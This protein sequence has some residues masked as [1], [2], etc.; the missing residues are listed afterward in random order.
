MNLRRWRAK[1]DEIRPES[2]HNLSRER[3]WW[4]VY[5]WCQLQSEWSSSRKVGGRVVWADV[6]ADSEPFNV[7]SR[8]LQHVIEFSEKSDSLGTNRGQV[9]SNKGSL[10]KIHPEWALF[11]GNVCK[12]LDILL[13][14]SID[15]FFTKLYIKFFLRNSKILFQNSIIFHKVLQIRSYFNKILLKLENLIEII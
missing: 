4:D 9:A 2:L 11:M 13:R 15:I 3:S 7:I 1:T 8:K 14:Y 5:Q 12:I 6:S 10:V